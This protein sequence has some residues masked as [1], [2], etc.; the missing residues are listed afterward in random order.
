MRVLVTWGSRHGGTTGIAK[1]ITAALRDAGI[2]VDPRPAH[3][4]DTI[5]GYDAAII[6]GA[7]YANRWHGEARRFVTRHLAAL[8]GL[9]V[10]MFSSGPLDDSAARGTLPPVRE[11]EVLIERVGALGHETFGGRLAPDVTG[12]M[13][14]A[15]VRDHAGDWRDPAR[16]RA[17]AVDIAARLATA[18]PVAPIEPP[19]RSLPRLIAHAITGWSACALAMS[20]LLAVTSP[21]AALAGHAIA[22]P[23]IF[24]VVARLYFGARGARGALP[25]AIAFTAITAVLDIATWSLRSDVALASFTGSWLPLALSFATIWAIGG[26]MSTLPWPKP[27]PRPPTTRATA[28]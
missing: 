5:A 11:V 3:D 21:R 8:R 2:D 16:I 6:G 17:W 19:A 26:T 24:A 1:I 4:I 18:R 7:L 23:L 15:M 22:A 9:P 25:V 27:T 12:W 20:G 10:W 14:R 13:A 28:H